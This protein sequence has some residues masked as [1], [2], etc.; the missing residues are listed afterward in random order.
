MLHARHFKDRAVK[1]EVNGYAQKWARF[2]FEAV[3]LCMDGDGVI[4]V[5]D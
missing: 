3:Y 2:F 5:S 4:P 1:T